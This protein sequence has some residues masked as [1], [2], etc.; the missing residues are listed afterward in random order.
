MNKYRYCIIAIDNFCKIAIAIPIV[1]VNGKT[2]CDFMITIIGHLGPYRRVL[3]DAG[4][5]FAG[6]AF[7]DFLITLGIERHVTTGS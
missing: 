6:N 2:M 3:V 1:A 7:G 5:Y 4:R